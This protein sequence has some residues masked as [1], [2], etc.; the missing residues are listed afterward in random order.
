MYCTSDVIRLQEKI[1]HNNIILCNN[2]ADSS[3]DLQLR[4]IVMKV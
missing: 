1:T 4:I 2:S 3:D